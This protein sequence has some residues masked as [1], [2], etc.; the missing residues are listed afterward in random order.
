MEQK[1]AGAKSADKKAKG[2]PKGRPRKM[3]E[4]GRQLF[5][6]QKVKKMYGVREKQFRRFFGLATRQEGAPGDNL[7]SLLERR[8]DNVVYRLKMAKTRDQSRQMVVHG[9]I[10]VN[11]KKVHTPSFFVS[12]NDVISLNPRVLDK[13]VFVENVVDKRMKVG[14]KVPEWLELDKQERIGRVLRKPVRQDI[15][16]PIEDHLIV[17]L[18]SKLG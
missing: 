10:W 15:Q 17:E 18:Y 14:I 12:E 6:K 16:A 4:Y 7:L 2:T 8:L 1:V 11:G 5:E 13:K 9:H 3:S